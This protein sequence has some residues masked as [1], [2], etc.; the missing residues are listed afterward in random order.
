MVGPG[1]DNARRVK[2]ASHEVTFEID[3]IEWKSG[4][5]DLLLQTRGHDGYIRSVISPSGNVKFS[6]WGSSYA[7]TN[8]DNFSGPSS[9]R[10]NT[11]NPGIVI[12]DGGTVDPAASEVTVEISGSAEG[13]VVLN[14]DAVESVTI[15]NFGSGYTAL[16]LS[17]IHI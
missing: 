4:Q 3:L 8:F 5:A 6:T 15:T 1:T 17:L 10:N 9:L 16:P 14:G 7:H 11:N 12:V 2:P 13:T